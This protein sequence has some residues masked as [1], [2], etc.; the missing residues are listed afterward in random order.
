MS[1]LGPALGLAFE[2]DRIEDDVQIRAVVHLGQKDPR[3]GAGNRNLTGGAV[4]GISSGRK[5]VEAEVT[6]PHPLDGCQLRV[7]GQHR[8]RKVID[9]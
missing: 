2:V 9:H 5:L 8:S 7:S 4:S 6:F 3:F 1:R